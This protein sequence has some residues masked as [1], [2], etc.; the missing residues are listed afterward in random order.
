MSERIVTVNAGNESVD[1]EVDEFTGITKTMRAAEAPDVMTNAKAGDDVQVTPE[2]IQYLLD[3]TTEVTVLTEDLLDELE[4]EE[5]V[6]VISH[7]TCHAFGQ[8]PESDET[9]DVYAWDELPDGVTD[10]DNA[11]IAGFTEDGSLDV[12]E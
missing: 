12:D 2:L 5:L 10:S 4:Q 8:T 11:T 7:V 1:I 3:I 9:A 6:R